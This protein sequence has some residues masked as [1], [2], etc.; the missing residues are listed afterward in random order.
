MLPSWFG[1]RAEVV[2][3]E[4]DAFDQFG[5]RGRRGGI[6]R[7]IAATEQQQGITDNGIIPA[8][9]PRPSVGEMCPESTDQVSPAACV[10]FPAGK[11]CIRSGGRRDNAIG[12][13]S[14]GSSS[15]SSAAD[16]DI[17]DVRFVSLS[18]PHRASVDPSSDRLPH[19]LGSPFIGQ[20]RI[21]GRESSCSLE[22]EPAEKLK[23]RAKFRSWPIIDQDDGR[24][25]SRGWR[26]SNPYKI[27]TLALNNGPTSGLRAYFCSNL[28]GALMERTRKILAA[29]VIPSG[30]GTG[31]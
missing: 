23:S 6:H 28:G 29:R 14:Q 30:S 17:P 15:R 26:T 8:G 2:P 10:A 24:F 27:S 13:G 20:V 4:V 12:C 31:E 7:Y 16:I 19:R 18:A 3:P 22:P 5:G 9:F 25:S 21:G 11:G 1:M